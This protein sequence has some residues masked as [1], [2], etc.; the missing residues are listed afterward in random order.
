MHRYIPRRVICFGLVFSPASICFGRSRTVLCEDVG[1]FQ[2]SK[3]PPWRPF[4]LSAHRRIFESIC[5]DRLPPNQ[6]HNL[7]WIMTAPTSVGLGGWGLPRSGPGSRGRTDRDFI[8]TPTSTKLI[9]VNIFSD[10]IARQLRD[11]CRDPP[12][13][14]ALASGLN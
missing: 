2:S 7:R 8:G 5:D 9:W 10:A 13:R 14:T 3:R 12:R 4:L 1:P 6:S 11:I